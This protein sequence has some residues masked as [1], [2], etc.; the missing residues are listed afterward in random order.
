ML[1]DAGPPGDGARDVLRAALARHGLSPRDVRAVVLTHGHRDHAGQAEWLRRH[2][3]RVYV[4]PDEAAAM[5]ADE[6]ARAEHLLRGCG[7]GPEEVAALRRDLAWAAGFEPPASWVPLA[8]GGEVDLPGGGAAMQARHVPGHAPGHVLLLLPDGAAF[9][10]DFLLPGIPPVPVVEDLDPAPD[11]GPVARYL[12]ALRRAAAWEL[13]PV[14]PGH[15]EPYPDLAARAREG[16]AWMER[17]LAHLEAVVRQGTRRV[18]TL[19]DRF[20][21]GAGG[22]RLLFAV[23]EVVAYLLCLEARGAVRLL[24]EPPLGV[25][26][27]D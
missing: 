11:G 20:F 6:R 14:Y 10:G 16:L 15:G 1:V 7:Y 4:H 19:V 21:P 22:L 27:A 13:G 9:A 3:A 12:A 24:R 25:E 5:G 2:G 17:R 8:E 26:P 18:R 23:S